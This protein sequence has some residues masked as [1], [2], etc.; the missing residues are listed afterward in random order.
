MKFLE[1]GG[2]EKE[3]DIKELENEKAK[4][5][6]SGKEDRLE[7]RF[8]LLEKRF[9]DLELAFDEVKEKL[10]EL[11]PK[12]VSDIL[13]RVGDLED[14][15]LIEN[16]GVR[17]LKNLLE[18]VEK[19]YKELASRKPIVSMSPEDLRKITSS[20]V[21]IIKS[22]VSSV[23]QKVEK[24]LKEI[25]EEKEKLEGLIKDIEKKYEE[26]ASRKPVLSMTPE[27][28]GRITNSVE[29]ILESVILPKVEQKVEERLKAIST[30]KGI[31]FAAEDLD[32]SIAKINKEIEYLKN[33][34]KPLETEIVQKIVSEISDLRTE[35]GKEIM[36][37]KDKIEG[38]SATKSDIDIKFLSSRVNTLKE[39]IDYLLNRKTE[40]DM[41]IEEIKKV[42]SK[43]AEK[44]V[45]SDVIK[46][47]KDNKK[48]LDEL[49]E[50]IASIENSLKTLKIVKT[51]GGEELY[52]KIADMYE[53]VDKKLKEAEKLA[54][55]SGLKAESP[56]D[57]QIEE[58]LD[59]IIFLESRL[60]AIEK[61]L[62]KKSKSEP[63]IID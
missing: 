47:I 29:P 1:E 57:S 43:I 49:S 35:T 26:L 45:S 6:E 41:K 5:I 16:L 40:I 42:V 32:K 28:L 48:T 19:K 44:T 55:A 38:V 31:H 13:Q 58:L 30:E 11:D 21:P 25:A 53:K 33:R 37:I 61:V 52:K 34:I 60:K 20:V 18:D 9:I 10:K 24:R 54:T 14:L 59:K 12:V 7:R 62:E 39:N 23:E 50:R 17:E 4:K 3:S 56:L 36:D 15:I 22:N 2:L 51:G 8:I 27:D 63:I 46:T